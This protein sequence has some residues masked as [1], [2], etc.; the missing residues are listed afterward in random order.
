MTVEIGYTKVTC[1]KCGETFET[2]GGF[3]GQIDT[4]ENPCSNWVHRIHI[5]MA[6]YP[7][8]LDM[9]EISFEVCDNCLAEWIENFE[10]KPQY[11]ENRLGWVEWD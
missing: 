1:N 7:S 4:K 5:P 11:G 9:T 6:G 8:F 10:I 2:E 3:S